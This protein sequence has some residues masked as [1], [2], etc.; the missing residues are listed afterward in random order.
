[1]DCKKSLTEFAP[2]GAKKTRIM[3]GGGVYVAENTLRPVSCV[4]RQAH[5]LCAV[6]SA[7]TNAYRT[8]LC[9]GI[10]ALKAHSMA[11]AFSDAD[12]AQRFTF[13]SV[14]KALF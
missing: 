2:A 7:K 11:Q 13:E 5:K 12:M 8:K 4:S 3:F 1:M 9:S 14:T 10:Y 6:R